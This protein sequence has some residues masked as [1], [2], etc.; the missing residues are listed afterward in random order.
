MNHPVVLESPVAPAAQQSSAEAT[1][2]AAAQIQQ[3]AADA[4][5]AALEVAK[6]VDIDRTVDQATRGISIQVPSGSSPSAVYEG[7]VSAQRVLR[8]QLQQLESKRDEIARDIS[9]GRTGGEAGRAG[10]E[11]RIKEIDAR[12]S[13]LDA[14][15]AEASV[16]VARAA[17]V[18]G[19]VVERRP[20]P[21]Q[22]PSDGV[23]VLGGMFMLVV[24][25]PLT[26]AYAR[27]LWK[28]GSTI[29]AP[30]PNDVRERLDGL[31][32]SIEAIGLE[33]ERIGEGQR[34]VTR[35]LAESRPV[36]HQLPLDRHVGVE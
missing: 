27:R 15:L 6:S 23:F 4:Q 33:V 25:L 10:L 5:R 30:V 1:Q 28:R 22:G 14:Q 17:A 18:P 2:Q 24:L 19:A 8:T 9:Q 29:I 11:A 31:T 16:A 26:I 21:Q 20:P 13:N 32:Q 36:E 12:I 35:V 3:A 7:L 34:F